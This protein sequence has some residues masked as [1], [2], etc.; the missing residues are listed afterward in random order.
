[1]S[2]RT[3]RPGRFGPFHRRCET[4]PEEVDDVAHSG[5]LWG[6]PRRNFFA[7]MIPA[8]KAWEGPLPADAVGVEFAA[9]WSR[10]P[11]LLP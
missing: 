3:R 5:Q 2:S 10:F 7:G 4:R 6:R 1:M 8:V 11:L 9:N